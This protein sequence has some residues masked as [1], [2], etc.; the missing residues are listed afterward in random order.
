MEAETSH[1]NMEMTPGTERRYKSGKNYL[2]LRTE[3]IRKSYQ[4]ED[5][6]KVRL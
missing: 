3:R 1:G 4:K 6:E 2:E 5:K